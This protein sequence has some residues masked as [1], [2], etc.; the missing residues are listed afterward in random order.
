MD[1][2]E[3]RLAIYSHRFEP[4]RIRLTNG[5]FYDVPRPGS[6]AIGNIASSIVVDGRLHQIANVNIAAIEPLEVAAQ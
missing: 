6:I 2:E 3:L 4:K 1:E 5:Q